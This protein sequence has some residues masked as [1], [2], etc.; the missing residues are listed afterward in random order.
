MSSNRTVEEILG[1]L[2]NFGWSDYAVF[3]TILVICAGIGIYFSLQN[4]HADG[5]DVL[6]FLL[7]GRNLQMFPVLSIIA[8]VVSGTAI[9]LSILI[10]TLLFS[11]VLIPVRLSSEVD[12]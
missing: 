6:N 2:R 9:Q 12:K 1:S 5:G 11:S 4:D 7:G 3:L 10:T 8:S